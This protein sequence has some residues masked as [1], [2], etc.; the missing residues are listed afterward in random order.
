MSILHEK[1]RAGNFTSSEIHRL[2]ETPAKAKTYIEE[3]NIERRMGICLGTE[4]HTRDMAWGNFLEQRVLDLLGM[5][6]QIQS[7]QTN[8]HPT[9]PNWVGTKDLVVRNIKVSEIKCYQ[10][11]NFALYTD[12]LLTGETEIIKKHNPKEYWQ[13]VSNASILSLPKGE[14]ITY[15]P[16]EKEIPEIRDMALNYGDIDR[17]KYTWIYESPIEALAYLPNDGYYKNLNVFE[18]EVPKVDIDLLTNKVITYSK[19]LNP[20]L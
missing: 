6:Y 7:K 10:R 2:M 3:K 4:V 16:Y 8:V 15:M 20:A 11:K 12:A 5:E 13:I 14:A 9:I 1:L 19:L 17:Y 18:F